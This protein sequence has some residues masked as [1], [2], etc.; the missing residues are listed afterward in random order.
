MMVV[1]VGEQG[2]N[3][4]WLQLNLPLEDISNLPVNS[5]GVKDLMS[6]MSPILKVPTELLTNRDLFWGT[7]IVNPALPKE[8]QTSKVIKQ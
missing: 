1:R 5:K 3:A 7:D 2:G 8:F 6:M 4:L